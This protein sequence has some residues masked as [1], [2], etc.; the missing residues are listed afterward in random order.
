MQKIFSFSGLASLVGLSLALT[1]CQGTVVVAPGG[2]G[3]CHQVPT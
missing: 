3:Y 1:A 2:P